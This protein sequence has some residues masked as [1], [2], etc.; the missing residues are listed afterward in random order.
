[1]LQV[2]VCASKI[3]EENPGFLKLFAMASHMPKRFRLILKVFGTEKPRD[4]AFRV[5]SLFKQTNERLNLE[6]HEIAPCYPW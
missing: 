1:M 4:T 5:D 2:R 3:R 6:Y